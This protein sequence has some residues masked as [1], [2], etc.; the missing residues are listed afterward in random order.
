MADAVIAVS[1]ETKADIERLFEVDPKR[2]H[3][4]HNGIDLDEYRKVDATG[5]LTRSRSR[6]RSSRSCC[7]WG[8]SRGKKGSF[9]WSARFEFMDPGFSNCALRRRAGHTGDRVKK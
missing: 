7:S 2:L 9:I 8:G 4:I 5:A 1:N 3:V 6:S